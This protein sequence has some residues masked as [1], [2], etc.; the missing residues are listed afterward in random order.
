MLE[1]VAVIA[2]N[3]GVGLE[4][5]Q[6]VAA[7]KSKHILRVKIIVHRQVLA[8]GRLALRHE[9]YAQI[10]LIQVKFLFVTEHLILNLAD[11]ENVDVVPDEVRERLVVTDDHHPDWRLVSLVRS[12]L[13]DELLNRLLVLRRD[14]W[15]P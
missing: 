5:Q 3:L 1:A 13:I 6:A 15:R 12:L 11:S 8:E 9:E 14:F 7:E 10:T 4:R 2:L